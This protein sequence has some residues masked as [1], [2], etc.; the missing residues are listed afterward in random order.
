GTAVAESRKTTDE[1]KYLRTYPNGKLYAAATS[2]F[3]FTHGATGIES[4]EDG[5]LSGDSSQ[6]FTT[7]LADILTGRN[8]RG[9]TVQLTLNRAAQ[10]AAYN[11]MR[12]GNGFKRG[13]V[14]ALD[15]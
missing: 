6:L 3:S 4:A 8:P 13:A 9:G 14:V 15:P 10:T 7:K 2:Y 12:V 1:L 11:A 5:I